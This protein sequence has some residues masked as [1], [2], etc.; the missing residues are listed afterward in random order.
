MRGDEPLAL[1]RAGG[2]SP[3]EEQLATDWAY[4]GRRCEGTLEAVGTES[5]RGDGAKVAEVKEKFGLSSVSQDCSGVSGE[6]LSMASSLG[7]RLIFLFF[8]EDVLA[9]SC[10]NAAPVSVIGWPVGKQNKGGLSPFFHLVRECFRMGIRN[11][12]VVKLSPRADG[13]V[14]GCTRREQVRS[15]LSRPLIRCAGYLISR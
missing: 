9:T 2:L 12:V 10:K 6:G 14:P 4:S 7:E 11:T 13:G 5:P 8:E 1:F 3:A 15:A